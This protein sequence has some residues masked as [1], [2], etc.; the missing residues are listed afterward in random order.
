MP[1]DIFKKHQKRAQA[2]MN[3]LHKSHHFTIALSNV[4]KFDDISADCKLTS[5]TL[6]MMKIEQLKQLTGTLAPN[7]KEEKE[8]EKEEEANEKTER[9]NLLQHLQSSG[10]HII[11]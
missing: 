4:E 8:K 9:Q 10:I 5:S 6:L 7:N 3:T 2:L 1:F 11:T